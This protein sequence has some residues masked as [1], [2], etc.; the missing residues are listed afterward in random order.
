MSMFTEKTVEG[1]PRSQQ[2]ASRQQLIS[3]STT[4]AP[5]VNEAPCLSIK[6]LAQ[7]LRI[8]R[9]S[10]YLRISPASRYFDSTFPRP[11]KI[12]NKSVRWLRSEVLAWIA[13]RIEER[14]H[15]ATSRS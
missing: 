14:D 12:G 9:S 6:D 8:G 1:I 10:I 11:V 4:T 3:P 13:A 2:E 15:P 7:L 5:C